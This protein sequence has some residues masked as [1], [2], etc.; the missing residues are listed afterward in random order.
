MEGLK[1]AV[2][3]ILI[4]G[5]SS[6]NAQEQGKFFCLLYLIS[7][8]IFSLFLKSMHYRVTQI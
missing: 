6:A 5:I 1:L 4:I 2:L 3:L 7:V 8:E